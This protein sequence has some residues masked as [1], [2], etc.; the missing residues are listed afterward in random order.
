MAR[1][2][3]VAKWWQVKRCWRQMFGNKVTERGWGISEKYSQHHDPTTRSPTF[4]PHILSHI[5][6]H[7]S[8]K[9]FEIQSHN[10]FIFCQFYNMS[11]AILSTWFSGLSPAV[12]GDISSG[13][14]LDISCDMFSGIFLAIPFGIC[15]DVRFDMS[16]CIFFGMSF[17]ILSDQLSGI[18]SGIFFWPVFSHFG[19]FFYDISFFHIP[20]HSSSH[21]CWHFVQKIS[22]HLVSFPNTTGILPDIFF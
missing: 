14:L 13:I 22:W 1:W 2:N 11:F 19:H 12:S 18:L 10:V 21:I 3:V 16:C 7:S 17:H 15:V 4:T 6:S 20:L 9:S 8:E 5:Y